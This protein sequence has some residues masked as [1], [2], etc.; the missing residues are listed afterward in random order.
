MPRSPLTHAE[1][2]TLWQARDVYRV[3]AVLKGLMLLFFLVEFFGYCAVG[4]WWLGPLVIAVQCGLLWCLRWALRWVGRW[5]HRGLWWS[6]D[7][8]QRA[9]QSWQREHRR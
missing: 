6:I 2:M 5:A 4:S 8:A 1:A 7:H 9:V 3:Q